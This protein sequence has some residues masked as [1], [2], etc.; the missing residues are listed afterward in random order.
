MKVILVK[1]NN[2]TEAWGPNPISKFSLWTKIVLD[3][4][5][6]PQF[7]MICLNKSDHQD[8][9]VLRNVENFNVLEYRVPQKASLGATMKQERINFRQW[10]KSC[11]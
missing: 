10:D 6:Y 3:Q 2:M 4:S 1:L 8:Y 11:I 9:Q 5:L 7:R